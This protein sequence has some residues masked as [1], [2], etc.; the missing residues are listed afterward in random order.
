MI[1]PVGFII[2]FSLGFNALNISV[3]LIIFPLFLLT[4]N[5]YPSF[6]I[7]NKISPIIV[8]FRLELT[9]VS[10]LKLPVSISIENNLFLLFEKNKFLLSVTISD[11]SNEKDD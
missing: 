6:E 3:I 10:Q 9:F 11:V 1:K 8:D 2:F 5:K 4:K 7:E